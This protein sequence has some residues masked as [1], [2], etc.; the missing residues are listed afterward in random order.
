MKASQKI[1]LCDDDPDLLDMYREIFAQL[2]DQPEIHTANSGPRALAMLEAEPFDL[3]ICDLKMPRMDGFQV[4]EIVRHKYPHLRTMVLTCNTDEQF[5]LRAY[6]LG[7]DL[8]C[9]KPASEQ[10]VK[11]WLNAVE[12]LLGRESG[13]SPVPQTAARPCRKE[14]LRVVVLDDEESVWIMYRTILETFYKE[15]TVVGC[16][17]GDEAWEELSRKDPDLFITDLHHNGMSCPEM[18]GCLANRKAKYPIL[19]I[20]GYKFPGERW[21]GWGSGLNVSYLTKSL[22]IARFRQVVETALRMPAQSQP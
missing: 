17:T 6:A 7:V 13:G 8:F 22:E 4:L 21:R 1:L 19:I 5:R 18:L 12:A 9:D 3:L 2:P 14:P 10:E 16:H 20:S 11:M 15:V